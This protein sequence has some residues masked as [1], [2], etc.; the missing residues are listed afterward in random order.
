MQEV[1]TYPLGLK[2]Q[3]MEGGHSR[4]SWLIPKCFCRAKETTEKMTTY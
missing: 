1:Q 3:R 2:R 4:G